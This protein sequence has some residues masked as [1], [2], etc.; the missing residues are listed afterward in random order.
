MECFLRLK[1]ARHA[2]GTVIILDCIVI[3]VGCFVI[4]KE[5][6]LS[7]TKIKFNGNFTSLANKK[8]TLYTEN[9]SLKLNR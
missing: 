3:G 2:E 4:V 7:V 1:F 8:I 6:K 9:T 5:R